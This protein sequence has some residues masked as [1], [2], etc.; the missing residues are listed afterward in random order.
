ML[1]TNLILRKKRSPKIKKKKHRRKK[2]EKYF[3]EK[4]DFND[5]YF[6][7]TMKEWK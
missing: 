4:A 3:K 2:L 5:K 7:E 6:F 1:Q